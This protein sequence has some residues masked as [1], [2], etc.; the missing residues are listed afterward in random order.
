MCT[1]HAKYKKE[2]VKIWKR[3]TWNWNFYIIRMLNDIYYYYFKLIW[4]YGS[5]YLLHFSMLF[6]VFPSYIYVPW[7]ILCKKRDEFN[8]TNI[9]KRRK[10]LS[11]ILCAPYKPEYTIS[12][13]IIFMLVSSKMCTMFYY[14]IKG[15]S[16]LFPSIT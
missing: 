9:P 5:W 16:S 1:L 13:N 15:Q 7:N 11:K 12:F 4:V 14:K 10:I 8:I 3:W 6:S 2:R